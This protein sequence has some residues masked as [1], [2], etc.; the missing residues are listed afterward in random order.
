MA[1]PRT[2]AAKNRYAAKAYDRVA[3]IVPK[4]RKRDIESFAKEK[5]LSINGYI[6]ELIW[7]DMKL[8][9][10]AWKAPPGAED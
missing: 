1:K 8:S 10:E 9:E 2:S 7:E 3:P 4:G 6:G 5:G